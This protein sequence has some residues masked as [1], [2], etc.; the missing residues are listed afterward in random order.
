MDIRPDILTRRGH[1]FN[2][3]NPDE[4]VIAIEDIATA[5]SNICRFNGHT[6]TFY[7][8]AQHSIFV[9][10]LVPEEHA[11]V[12]LMHDAAE[13]YVGDVT[14]P[15]KN[16]LPEYKVIEDRVHTAIFKNFGLDPVLPPC[17]KKAD[18]IMLATEQ[19]N[20]MAEHDDEWALLKGIEPLNTVIV[21]MSPEKAAQRFVK[22]FYEL[23]LE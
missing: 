7:S 15:L 20:L 6:N 5:L 4:S 17:V 8:V 10:Q 23:W 2:F 19:K 22:R 12:A 1:Y 18:L 13:A 3:I 21:A 14:R 16:L 9:S 11:L